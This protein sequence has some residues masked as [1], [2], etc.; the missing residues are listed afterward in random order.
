MRSSLKAS[1]STSLMAWQLFRSRPIGFST[2]IRLPACANPAA[3]SPVQIG[4]NRP[5]EVER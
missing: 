5:G 1:A 2:T 4:P 3:F